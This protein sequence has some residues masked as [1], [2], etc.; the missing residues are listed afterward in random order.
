MRS[1]DHH[2]YNFVQIKQYQTDPGIDSGVFGPKWTYEV[3][4]DNSVIYTVTNPDARSFDNVTVKMANGWTPALGTY[5]NFNFDPNYDRKG[6]L[7][8]ERFAEKACVKIPKSFFQK[9]IT[10]IGDTQ[11]SLLH[12]KVL[13]SDHI[14]ILRKQGFFHSKCSPI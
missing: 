7:L 5:D 3:S 9:T 1:R 10:G 4:L 13:K 12:K 6:Y 14:L 2:I 11:G 8:F